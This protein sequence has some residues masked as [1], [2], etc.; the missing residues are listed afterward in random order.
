M[1]TKGRGRKIKPKKESVRIISNSLRYCARSTGQHS[2]YFADCYRAA[3]NSY[4][5][6]TTLWKGHESPQAIQP[7][8]AIQVS[9][10][11]KFWTASCQNKI[12]PAEGSPEQLQPVS[13][14]DCGGATWWPGKPGPRALLRQLCVHP[15]RASIN[16]M[17]FDKATALELCTQ[18]KQFILSP[19]RGIT[20]TNKSLHEPRNQLL[21]KALQGHSLASSLQASARAKQLWDTDCKDSFHLCCVISSTLPC[22][23]ARV[24]AQDVETSTKTETNNTREFR[25]PST[26]L[27]TQE[28][29]VKTEKASGEEHACQ[30]R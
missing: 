16:C 19:I 18:V 21:Q 1:T 8:S 23:E 14:T 25:F 17:H 11:I 2:H 3:I 6:M 15:C 9:L 4:R 7:N 13:H 29:Q 26:E 5:A 24:T 28:T 10:E 20:N 12:F 30:Y 27:Q 22:R